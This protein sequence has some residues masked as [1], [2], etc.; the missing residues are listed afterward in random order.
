MFCNAHEDIGLFYAGASVVNA[1]RVDDHDTFSADLGLEDSN[2]NRA[3]LEA[4][5]DLLL[6]SRNMVDEL[7]EI[8]SS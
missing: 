5:A 7:F 2:F 8:L 3:R 1:W 4:P 6:L